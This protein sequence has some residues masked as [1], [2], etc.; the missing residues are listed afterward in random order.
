VYQRNID[1]Y[2]FRD[3]AIG[4]LRSLYCFRRKQQPLRRKHLAP[5]NFSASNNSFARFANLKR[6]PQ[7][8]PV[9]HARERRADASTALALR[10]ATESG[11]ALRAKRPQQQN[12]HCSHD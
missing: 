9:L 12:L 4:I 6:Y 3:S 11:Y 8:I 10:E 5:D 2:F 7:T 1:R